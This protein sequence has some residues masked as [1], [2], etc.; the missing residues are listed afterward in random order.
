MMTSPIRA[1]CLVAMPVF[2][3][4]EAS[5]VNTHAMIQTSFKSRNQND[6]SAK[7]KKLYS[8]VEA[9]VSESLA[10]NRPLEESER[11]AI[12]TM[13]G[14]ITGTMLPGIDSGHKDDLAFLAAAKGALLKCDKDLDSDMVTV[15]NKKAEVDVLDKKHVQ[16]RSSEAALEAKKEQK[17]KSVKDFTTSVRDG[18]N[19]TP[20]SVPSNDD[21]L[22]EFFRTL[23]LW[24][25]NK[26]VEYEDKS[27]AFNTSSELYD[28]KQKNCTGQQST[29][30]I[31]Y[32]SWYSMAESAADSHER[33]V[34]EGGKAWDETKAAVL[35]NVEQRKAEYASIKH[36][37]CL[38][39]LLATEHVAQGGIEACKKDV[40]TSFLDIEDKDLHKPKTK[41]PSRD[42]LKTKPG[43]ADWKKD[44]YAN[45]SAPANRVV[46]CSAA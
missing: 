15:N 29:F 30:E 45:L 17:R 28:E 8:R 42:D 11:S 16:C 34:A 21:E 2:A 6:A 18:G 31:E 4:S 20:P 26:L 40:D 32:C 43:D 35:D 3:W 27:S 5:Q 10:S 24:A 7:T 1:I 25:E 13:K 23:K 37:E 36:I 33:C 44:K 46:A 9:L 41:K 39:D 19:S 38:L 12:N 14:M 22:E